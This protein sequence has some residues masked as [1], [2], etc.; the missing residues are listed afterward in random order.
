MTNPVL[1]ELRSTI[2]PEPSFFRR[3]HYLAA[4]VEAL[5]IGKDEYE[6]VVSVGS[7]RPPSD[8]YETLPWSRTYPITWRWVDQQLF[9]KLGYRASNLDRASI[10][11]RAKFL[12]L[13]DSDILFNDD[14]SELLKFVADPPSVCGVM[15]HWPP[16]KPT[17]RMPLIRIRRKRNAK[18]W[19]APLFEAFGLEPPEHEFE[20]AGWKLM[21]PTV[22]RWSPAYF[23]G[24]I[25]VGPSK[26]MLEMLSHIEA[27][28]SVVHSFEDFYHS[29]Q[30]T[31]TLAQYKAGVTLRSLPMRYNFPNDH[32]FE[33]IYPVE[34]ENVKII[35]YLRRSIIDRSRDFQS[36]QSVQ[37]M[38]AR[39]DLTGVNRI[40]QRKISSLFQRVA[41]EEN[42]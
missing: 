29:A 18:K 30:I 5:G 4:S 2:A 10:G 8:L 25:I 9:S 35:H 33:E 7:V 21:D 22:S 39:D 32:R 36:A 38:M 26:Q 13:V 31:R 19:W 37:E 20:L 40:F 14:I 27:A 42:D 1:L 16:F 28:D 24:G 15:A 41:Q 34:S 3:I 23:N 12:M 11:S 17:V 6:I